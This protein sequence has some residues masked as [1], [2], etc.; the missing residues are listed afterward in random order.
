[1]YFVCKHRF[2]KKYRYKYITPE[3]MVPWR[4]VKSLQNRLDECYLLVTIDLK[5]VKLGLGVNDEVPLGSNFGSLEECGVFGCDC[6]RSY[7]GYTP[8]IRSNLMEQGCK[9]ISRPMYFLL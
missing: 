8:S 6:E 9:M 2:V 7:F 4:T 3:R 5:L 1:M